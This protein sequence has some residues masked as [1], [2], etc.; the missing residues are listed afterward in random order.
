M[1]DGWN[2]KADGTG[3]VVAAFPATFAAGTTTY[4]AQWK[5]DVRG[6]DAA[7]FSFRGTYNGRERG[8]AL[9]S[10]LKMKDAKR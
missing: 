5:L 9:P 3:D 4:Y 7:A 10:A 8:I 2:T 6:L 1:F